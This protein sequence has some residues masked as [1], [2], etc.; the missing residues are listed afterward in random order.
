VVPPRLEHVG[1]VG[2]VVGHRVPDLQKV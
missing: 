1:V 2:V